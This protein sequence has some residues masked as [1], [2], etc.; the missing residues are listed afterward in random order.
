MCATAKRLES[1]DLPAKA[2][3]TRAHALAQ[4]HAGAG[5]L[6]KFEAMDA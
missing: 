1:Q 5:K 6:A 3:I 4:T 2:D